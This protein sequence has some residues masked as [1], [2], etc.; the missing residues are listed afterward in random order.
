MIPLV[1]MD[2]VVVKTKHFPQTI[3]IRDSIKCAKKIYFEF[4]IL[5]L[6][7]MLKLINLHWEKRATSN[8]PYSEHDK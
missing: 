1:I 2:Y 3:R 7:I 6:I 5:E 4:V 8:G